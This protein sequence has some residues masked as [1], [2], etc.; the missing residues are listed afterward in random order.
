MLLKIL[1]VMT[2]FVEAIGSG[3]SAL[4][5]VLGNLPRTK[6]L[7]MVTGSVPLGCRTV[8]YFCKNYGTVWGCTLAA[9]KGI[10]QAVKFTIKR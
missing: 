1:V 2:M 8:R 10:K 7:T 9:G 4:G 5:L 6:H 3:A